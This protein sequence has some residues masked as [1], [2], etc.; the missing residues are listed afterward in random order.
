M[1]TSALVLRNVGVLSCLTVLLS[2]CSS[3]L[4]EKTRAME[5]AHNQHQLETVLSCYAD[6]ARFE[7]VGEWAVQGKEA[8]RDLFTVDFLLNGRLVFS[9]VLVHGDTVICKATEQ[10]DF[11]VALGLETYNYDRCEFRFRNGRIQ[12]ARATGAPESVATNERAAKAF[13]AWA[14]LNRREEVTRL[15]GGKE[16]TLT[17]ENALGWLKLVRDWRRSTVQP[18]KSI[19]EDQP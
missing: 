9:D 7:M 8:L 18:T 12:E 4:A 3:S 10:S 14:D 11:F 13:S 2:G 5:R 17:P 1:K 19:Q 15:L 16:F 6:D